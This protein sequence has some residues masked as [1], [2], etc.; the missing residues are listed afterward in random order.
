MQASTPPKPAPRA[1]PPRRLALP[2]GQLATEVETLAK[3][4]L[5]ARDPDMPPILDSLKVTAGYE[6]ALGAVARRR[7]RRPRRS[8]RA[9]ALAV[10]EVARADGALPTDVEPLS[11]YVEAPPELTR[12]LQARSASSR[13]RMGPSCSVT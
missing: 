12:R 8:E 5:P 3:L 4:L 2:P 11:R 13:P 6:T 9:G 1:K 10:I 7:S